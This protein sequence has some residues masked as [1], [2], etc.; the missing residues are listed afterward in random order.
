MSELID[1]V[2]ELNAGR[3]RDALERALVNAIVEVVRPSRVVL[4]KIVNLPDGVRV[5]ER[6]N[7]E[8]GGE[9]TVARLPENLRALARLER[10]G[11]AG[12]VG[13]GERR[14]LRLADCSAQGRHVYVAPV[15][16]DFGRVAWVEV[17]TDEPLGQEG[18]ATLAAMMRVYSNHIAVLDYSERDALTRL[19]NRKTF[20]DTFLRLLSGTPRE[21]GRERDD[22][23]GSR[24]G[25]TAYWLAMAD[26]DH[27]KRINDRHGH[28]FGDEVL[29]MIARL[30][31]ESFRVSDRLYRF[32]GEEFAIVL[33]R[34]SRQH[35]GEVF[36]RFREAVQKHRFARVGEVTIS[37]G[38]TRIRSGDTPT[39]A[40]ERADAAL[41]HAKKEGRNRV[42]AYET[43]VTAGKIRETKPNPSLELF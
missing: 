37:I 39:E 10:Y 17:E 43:L 6:L 22:Q 9:V 1:T 13:T 3:D 16:N 34:T 23:C 25:E 28:P 33:D 36:E 18:A 31:R 42:Y 12:E 29:V 24:S 26:I 21:S 20:D 8:R 11:F 7:F 38:F 19:R 15:R 14:G 4:C 32:G 30:M 27:F 5:H 40:L 35:A 41:Y 2:A